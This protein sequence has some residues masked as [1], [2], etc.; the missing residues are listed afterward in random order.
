M[1]APN[2]GVCR[3]PDEA[4]VCGSGSRHRG[5]RSHSGWPAGPAGPVPDTTFS[6]ASGSSSWRSEWSPHDRER[7]PLARHDTNFKAWKGGRAPSDRSFPLEVDAI[8]VAIMRRTTHRYV[9]KNKKR[10]KTIWFEHSGDYSHE[11]RTIDELMEAL[12]DKKWLQSLVWWWPV[13]W[14]FDKN[15][16]KLHSGGLTPP[17]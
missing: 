5:Q 10:S 16:G 4:T 1:R 15:F 7:W 6:L 11:P 9:L 13:R 8:S 2:L 12:G 3:T 14:P 17:T